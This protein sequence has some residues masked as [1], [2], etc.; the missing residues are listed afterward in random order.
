[1]TT[2]VSRRSLL[3]LGAG[4]GASAMFADSAL[5]KAPKL[6][7]QSPYFHRLK[8]GDAEVAGEEI[9]LRHLI[10]H[11][12]G[13]L[14][15]DRVFV[16]DGAVVIRC[17][18]SRTRRRNETQHGQRNRVDPRSWNLVSG[19]G[20]TRGWIDHRREAGKVAGAQIGVWQ[21]ADQG[22][23]IQ[24][25]QPLEIREEEQLVVEYGTA[26]AEAVIVLGQVRLGWGEVVASIES[27]A[28][29]EAEAGAVKSILSRTQR[30]IDLTA[31]CGAEFR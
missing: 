22:E 26:E 20:L 25:G 31:A 14:R 15:G 13:A 27:V 18:G 17:R 5:A 8:V 11:L 10:I 7:T 9:L 12:D 30:D 4:L 3:A 19:K 23:P 29:E 6:G 2:H 16:L 24:G 28:A 21:R 1:M